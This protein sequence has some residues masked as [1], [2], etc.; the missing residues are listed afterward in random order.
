MKLFKSIDEKFAEI[1]FK[2]IKED[3]FGV[4]YE[5]DN[6]PEYEVQ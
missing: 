5:R 6:F 3:V 4:R 1:G 2:K